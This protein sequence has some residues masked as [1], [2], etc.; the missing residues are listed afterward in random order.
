[1]VTRPLLMRP[2]H[3]RTAAA[4]SK[5]M[6]PCCEKLP[7]RSADGM[8]ASR[9]VHGSLVLAVAAVAEDRGSQLRSSE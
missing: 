5:V 2:W 4:A 3:G 9:L 7:E 1:M 6:E 8:R